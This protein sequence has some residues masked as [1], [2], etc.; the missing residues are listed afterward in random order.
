MPDWGTVH[1]MELYNHS[2]S[3]VPTSYA[4]EAI[5]IAGRLGSAEVVAHLHS[6][7]KAW[8]SAGVPGLHTNATVP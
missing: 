1:G 6:K 8:V 2:D 5:N 4:M 7:L 3:P